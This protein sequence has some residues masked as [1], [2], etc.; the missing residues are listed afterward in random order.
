MEP[1]SEESAPVV[2]RGRHNAHAVKPGN[3]RRKKK[4]AKKLVVVQG[5]MLNG[6]QWGYLA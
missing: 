1:L 6:Q 2:R 5:V 4:R 3:G